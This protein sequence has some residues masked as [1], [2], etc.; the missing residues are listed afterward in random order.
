MTPLTWLS[1]ACL[2]WKPSSSWETS[3][4]RWLQGVKPGLQL[5]VITGSGKWTRTAKDSSCWDLAV[6]NTFFKHKGQHKVAWYHPRSKH[7]HQLDMILTR[8]S[9]LNSIKNT[10]STPSADFNTDHIL[11]CSKINL[12]AHKIYHSKTKSLSCINS[13]SASCKFVT[14]RLQEILTSLGRGRT[15]ATTADAKWEPPSF[16]K[17]WRLLVRRSIETWTGVTKTGRRWNLL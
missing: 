10:Y 4:P 6:T 9:D 11:V 12:A 8:K 7:W 14:Q 16:N 5:S 17:G 15:D 13:S 3:M 1:K 2:A